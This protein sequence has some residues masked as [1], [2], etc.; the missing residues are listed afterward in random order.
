WSGSPLDEIVRKSGAIDIRV[1]AGDEGPGMPVTQERRRPRPVGRTLE[2]LIALGFV[3][4]AGIVAQVLQ[5]LRGLHDPGLVFLTAILFTALR[6]GLGPSIAA[7][8][9]SLLVY[10]FCF[11]D[12]LYTLSLTKSGDF[13]SL[14]AFLVVAVLTSNLM[15]RVRDQADVARRRAAL[16]E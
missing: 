15:T 2:Y 5:T 3:G 14:L 7:S 9:V 10:D 13:L 6:C 12:P 11:V 16:T 4:L 8:V 1:I